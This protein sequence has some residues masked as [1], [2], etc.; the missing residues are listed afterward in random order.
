MLIIGPNSFACNNIDHDLTL[1]GCFVDSSSSVRNLG[2]LFDSNLSFK[3]IIAFA[4]YIN[5]YKLNTYIYIY[6]DYA[7]NVKCRNVNS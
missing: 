1:D 5:I 7:L 4:T 6:I 3:K 2:V